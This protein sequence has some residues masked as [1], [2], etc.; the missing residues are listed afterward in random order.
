M[1]FLRVRQQRLVR[2][3]LELVTKFRVELVFWF[4]I[5][6]TKIR[7]S[8]NRRLKIEEQTTEV[9]KDEQQDPLYNQSAEMRITT[10]PNWAVRIGFGNQQH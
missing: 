5:G 8:D 9:I 6:K 7:N 10:G 2:N 3:K 4:A 1:L